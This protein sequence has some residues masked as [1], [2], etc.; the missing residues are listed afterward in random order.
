MVFISIVCKLDRLSKQRTPAFK[1]ENQ[2]RCCHSCSVQMS[3]M[4]AQNTEWINYTNG[5][6]VYATVL[7]G[8]NIWIGTFEGWLI[9]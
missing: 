6:G 5:I 9:R 1:T 2:G 3:A 4:Y 8:D 7:E